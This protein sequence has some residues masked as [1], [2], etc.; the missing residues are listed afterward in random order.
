MMRPRV[1]SN[2]FEERAGVYRVAEIL[3]G[4]SLIFRETAN[5]DVGIDGQVE[6]VNENNEATGATIAV[7]IK[8]GTSYL[9]SGGEYWKYYPANKHRLYWETYPLPVVLLIHDP[10]D[11]A[12]YW[13]DARR[14]L[15]SDQYNNQ[16]IVVPKANTL[17]ESSRFD[18]F[19]SS[20]SANSGL[21]TP[22]ELLKH[23]ALTYSRNASFPLSHLD[24]FLEGLTDIGRKLFFS[25]GM[26]WSLAETR[27]SDD[28]PTGVGM[29][30]SEQ[31]FLDLYIRFL[32][33]QSIALIDYSDVLIDLCDR[34]LFPTLLVPLTSRGRAVRDLCRQI[35]ST[36]SPY[37]IT[38]ATVQLAY[39]PHLIPRWQANLDVANK[40][41][42]YFLES[43]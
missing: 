20:G 4:M 19:E 15:R 25:A 30:K 32:V 9:K 36:G 5:A 33:E 39:G 7:Q 26:C 29:G 31:V 10:S 34:E 42:K 38:E 11:N 2:Y 41:E 12:V 37:A 27:I 17:T 6:L 28:A 13:V 14:Q 43:T 3:T 21:L 22:H 18:L 1:N 8:S 35:G 16:F 24:I 23:L 40:V